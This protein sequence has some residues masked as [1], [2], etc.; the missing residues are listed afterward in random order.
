MGNSMSTNHT[1]SR[2]R[3][4]QDYCKFFFPRAKM[5]LSILFFAIMTHAICVEQGAAESQ[6]ESTEDKRVYSSQRRA[7]RQNGQRAP[8]FCSEPSKTGVCRAYFHRFF[9]DVGS[10]KCQEFIYGGCGGNRNNFE[11]KA[12]CETTCGSKSMRNRDSLVDLCESPA[13]PGLCRAAFP[14]FFYNAESFQCEPFLYGGCGG[15]GNNFL[16]CEKKSCSF[17]ATTSNFCSNARDGHVSAHLKFQVNI[18]DG[19]EVM[20]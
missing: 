20:T 6:N 7:Y 4:P 8:S 3:Q 2:Y 19:L 12:E 13:E 11:T 1:N 18:L 10:G 9:F 5:R 14:R 16:G 17:P 15:N